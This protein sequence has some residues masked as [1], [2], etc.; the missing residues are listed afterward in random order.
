MLQVVLHCQ[1]ITLNDTGD[2]SL[3]GVASGY[4][5]EWASRKHIGWLNTLKC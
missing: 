5:I 3:V 2:N 4:L 1:I